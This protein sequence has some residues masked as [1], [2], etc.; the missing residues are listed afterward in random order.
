VNW[1]TIWMVNAMP[2]KEAVS[3]ATPAPNATELRQEVAAVG[4][5]GGAVVE[6]LAC[7]EQRRQ[8]PPDCAWRRPGKAAGTDPVVVVREGEAGEDQAMTSEVEAE[9]LLF[10]GCALRLEELG[11]WG[12]AL[13]HREGEE[14]QGKEREAAEVREGSMD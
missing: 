6:D 5:A 8:L 13:R 12:G 2:T 11:P 10:W 1:R 14:G 3:S 7:E 4:A 9:K